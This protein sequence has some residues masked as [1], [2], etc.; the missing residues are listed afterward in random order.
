MVTPIL[1]YNGRDEMPKISESLRK[2]LTK[3]VE[4]KNRWLGQTKISTKKSG[5]NI[6]EKTTQN[7]L[8]CELIKDDK[9]D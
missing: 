1:P 8:G 9:R 6:G 3:K 4:E 5:Q 7:F 2:G